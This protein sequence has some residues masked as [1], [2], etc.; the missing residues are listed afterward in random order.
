MLDPIDLRILASLQ[1]NARVSNADIAR[2]VDMAPSAI[3]ERIKKLEQRGF[4][5]GYE[6]RLAP[7]R[8][9][10]RKSAQ[11][12]PRSSRSKRSIKSLARIAT[13]SSCACATPT[14]LPGSSAC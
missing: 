2:D 7:K 11:S 10:R 13:S 6:A 5:T 3:L 12:S 8:R 9:A 1:V 4:V 14:T